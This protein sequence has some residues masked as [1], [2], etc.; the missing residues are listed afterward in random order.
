MIFRFQ[1]NIELNVLV[2]VGGKLW[3]LTS[4]RGWAATSGPFGKGKAP[5]GKYMVGEVKAIDPSANKSFRD[6][7]GL[8]WFAPLTPE[9]QT[10]RSSL[11]LHPD[12]GVE[13]TEGCV[14]LRGSTKEFYDWLLASKNV[15]LIV[16]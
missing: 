15:T 14:G 7:D 2:F 16:L 11:G 8:A 3:D 4:G 5:K 1:H 6:P 13:G 10:D 12:G 9:F